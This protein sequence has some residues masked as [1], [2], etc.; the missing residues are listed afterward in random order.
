MSYLLIRNPAAMTAAAAPTVC[1]DKAASQ[2]D[3]STHAHTRT[4]T[5]CLTQVRSLDVIAP[6]E[7][8]Y[9]SPGEDV[10]NVNKCNS[11]SRD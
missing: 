9:L 2:E 3:K 5:V 6:A 7:S 11:D 8:A 4:H 10:I 1:P